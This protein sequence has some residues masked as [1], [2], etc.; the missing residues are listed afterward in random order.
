MDKFVGPEVDL[1]VLVML[2]MT[3]VM[4]VGNDSWQ[5]YAL[6]FVNPIIH[7][8]NKQLIKQYFFLV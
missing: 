4:T 6:L 2:A 3:L 5:L 8:I 1:T 7:L